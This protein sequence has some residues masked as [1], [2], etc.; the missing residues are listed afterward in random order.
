M[1]SPWVDIAH[2]ESVRTP[3]T[4]PDDRRGH[5]TAEPVI[6]A[7][8]DKS[9]PGNAETYTLRK[10]GNNHVPA[11][12]QTMLRG[13]FGDARG[14]IPTS[15]GGLFAVQQ[16]GF[17]DVRGAVAGERHTK[18]L[19]GEGLKLKSRAHETK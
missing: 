8:P 12:L 18:R 6:P 13:G 11:T 10:R 17:A 19:S 2:S 16:H 5:A 9:I 3:F 4:S 7:S 1:P 15:T 14:R